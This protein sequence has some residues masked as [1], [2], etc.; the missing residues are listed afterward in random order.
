MRRRGGLVAISVLCLV[1]SG[2]A[3]VSVA[4]VRNLPP[5]DQKEADADIRLSGAIGDRILDRSGLCGA[6]R[7]SDLPISSRAMYARAEVRGAFYAVYLPTQAGDHDFQLS[8]VVGDYSGPRRYD[9]GSPTGG[10]TAVAH[11]G[12]VL[13]LLSGSTGNDLA[14]VAGAGSTI[15]INPDGQSGSLDLVMQPLAGAAS[16]GAVGGTLTARG[17]FRCAS[18][19]R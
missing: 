13:R 19:P 14:W 6:L 12:D 9:V 15:T 16:S 11:V 17:T 5:P 8:V 10:D 1:L 4:F 3:G 2:C 7:V 18:V